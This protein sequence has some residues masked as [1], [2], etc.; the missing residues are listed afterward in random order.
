MSCALCRLAGYPRTPGTSRDVP[1]SLLPVRL[2]REEEEGGGHG[3][4]E[5]Q[6]E[7]EVDGA[8]GGRRLAGSYLVADIVPET[9]FIRLTPK[10]A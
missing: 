10:L 8:S 9:E 2:E 4:Q 7:A 5:G 1:S 6:E 3:V